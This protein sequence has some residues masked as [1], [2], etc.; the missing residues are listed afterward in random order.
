[1][2]NWSPA[3]AYCAS[4]VANVLY[5]ATTA[6][7]AGLTSA[8]TVSETFCSLPY[9]TVAPT[10]CGPQAAPAVGVTVQLVVSVLSYPRERAVAAV[11][12]LAVQPAGSERPVL[13]FAS[14]GLLQ[15]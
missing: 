7:G 9:V 10:S 11:V 8:C 3:W 15:L 14:L 4:V 2:A 12:A 5:G 13:T 6:P 1:M